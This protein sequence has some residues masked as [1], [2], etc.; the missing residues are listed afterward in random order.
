MRLLGELCEILDVA[1][2]HFVKLLHHC[3]Q[4]GLLPLEDSFDTVRSLRQSIQTNM[5]GENLHEKISSQRV[6]ERFTEAGID[7]GLQL[8]IDGQLRGE[9]IDRIEGIQEVKDITI[10]RV[11][12]VVW[13]KRRKITCSQLNIER[14]WSKTD[15]W[16]LII[17]F[18]STNL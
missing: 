8:R 15:K 12:A 14:N 13:L 2:K 3:V 16:N 6:E 18:Q 9:W 1:I 5:V 7:E 17:L 4:G 11:L 10:H